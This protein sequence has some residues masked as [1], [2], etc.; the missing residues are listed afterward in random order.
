PPLPARADRAH[1]SLLAR[2]P[3]DAADD[4][5]RARSDGR[6][7]RDGARTKGDDLRQ[8]ALEAG[9]DLRRVADAERRHLHPQDPDHRAAAARVRAL[10]AAGGGRGRRRQGGARRRDGRAR[11]RAAD[12]VT[13]W[14][15]STPPPWFIQE[16]SWAV[17]CG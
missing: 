12:P 13:R 10:P 2:P 5:R 7:P 3:Q 4:R 15:R 11:T 14:L 17:A 16:P 8:D 1:A 6:L 9:R